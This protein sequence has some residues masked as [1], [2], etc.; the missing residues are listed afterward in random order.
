MIE[1]PLIATHTDN[2][3]G[4]RNAMTPF[5]RVLSLSGGTA[6]LINGIRKGGLSGALQAVAGAYGLFRGA[7]GHC[8]L[9]QALMQTPFEQQFSAEHD[10]PLSEAVT[11]SITIG[12]PLDEVREFIKTT[13]SIGSL[14]RWVDSIEE[15]DSDTTQ[16]T[17]HVPPNRHLCWTLIQSDSNDGNTV[18]WK[19][20]D[21]APWQ[22]DVSVSFDQAPAGRG[23]QVKVVMVCR[24]SMGKLGYGFARA[25]SM[26]TDKALLN[27]LLAVKQQLETGEVAIN[28][29]R[30]DDDQDFF[31]L[32]SGTD[33]PSAGSSN[34]PVNVGVAIEGG[35]V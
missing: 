7:T 34:S 5:E 12:R 22:H 21:G 26:F 27:A 9:K 3:A 6:L 13:K 31:Y 11:R 1:Y 25:L 32:H 28:R 18:H 16:W 2:D 8:A 35:I 30:P 15:L 29:L 23:T 4:R 10:W 33:T 24:P 14:L 20:P 19:T 17:M